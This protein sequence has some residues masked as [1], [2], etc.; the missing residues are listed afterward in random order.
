VKATQ[1][2]YHAAGATSFIE[3]PVVSGG[4]A[5]FRQADSAR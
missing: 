4:V 3:L 2:V 1:R 5:G